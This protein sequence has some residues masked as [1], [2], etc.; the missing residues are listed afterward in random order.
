MN[1][2]EEDYG[3]MITRHVTNEITNCYWNECIQCIRNF[4][5]LKKIVI[6]DDNSNQEYVKALNEYTGV[7]YVQSEY[8]GRGELLPYYYLYKYHYFNYAVI[9]HDSIFFQRRIHFET[10]LKKQVKVMPFWHFI[11]EKKENFNNIMRIT[12]YL[13]NNEFIFYTLAKDKQYEVLNKYNK[14][15]WSGCFGLQSFIQYD[16]ICYLQKKYNLF[17]LLDAVRNRSDRCSLERVMGAIF[18]IEYLQSVGQ[19]SLFGNIY[20]YCPW[21]Y[22]YSNYCYDKTKKNTINKINKINMLPIIKV[23]TG[24]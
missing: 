21:G 5:P 14:N 7:E 3:F 20:T 9:I 1:Q 13:S 18:F 22:S 24:R 6:I 8:C 16:F 15:V 11:S 17:H 4:Y 2:S 23:W 10:L 12:N 19:C